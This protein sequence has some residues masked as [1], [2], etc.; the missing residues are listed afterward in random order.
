MTMTEVEIGSR[1]AAR[2]LTLRGIVKRWK[3]LPKPVL[4]GVD[5]E[6]ERGTVIAISGRNGTGKTTL[7]RA[8][9]GMI[10]PDEGEVRLAG[11]N[12]ERDRRA[13]QRRVGFV[14]AG[15]AALYAR[16]SVDDHLALWGKLS[17]MTRTERQ[18]A[19][20]SVLDHFELDEL[21]GK[22]T[23]RLSMGQRQRLRLALG[24]M[25][26]PEVVLLDEPENSL[27]DEA[28]ALLAKAIEQVRD[29]GGAA[30]ICSPSGVHDALTFDRRL[31]L[32]D[33]KLGPA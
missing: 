4:D 32:A 6:V 26:S 21:R 5:L 30:V 13:F 28:I 1:E 10:V 19:T 25:H 2:P 29:R 12:P 27:D 7:L 11:I 8:A 17:L 16:L 14:S 15:N 18:A 22:R 24:F 31:A 33:G 9:A 20:R 23:D 3:G